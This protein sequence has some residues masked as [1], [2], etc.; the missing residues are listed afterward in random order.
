MVQ[1]TLVGI[2]L[3]IVGLLVLL[4]DDSILSGGSAASEAGIAVLGDTLVGFLGGS[5]STTL[6]GLRDVV[7]GVLSGKA[8]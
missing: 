1:L 7:G 3:N 5:G 8:S 4:V 2:G 6:D